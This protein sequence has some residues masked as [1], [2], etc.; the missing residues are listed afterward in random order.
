[1]PSG[2]GVISEEQI[3]AIIPFVPEGIATFLL[4]SKTDAPGIVAQHEKCRPS[5][6]QLCDRVEPDVHRALKAALPTVKLVQVIHV[7][8]EESI[9]EALLQAKS[10][11]FLLLDS[12]N[13]N[14]A[15]KSLGGTGKAHNW[16]ISREIVR[17]SPLPVY[18]AGGLTPENV[19]DAIKTVQP[20]GVDVCSGVRTEGKLDREKVERFVEAVGN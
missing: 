19:R 11:D 17:L 8:G 12:G 3:A 6:F 1:M 10:V 13:P 16:E 18:L 14:L 5:V 9:D 15:T 7:L 2:P 20:Y 4:T